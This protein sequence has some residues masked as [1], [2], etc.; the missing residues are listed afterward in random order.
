M[1]E[2]SSCIEEYSRELARS[3][4]ELVRMQL[5]LEQQI[6]EVCALFSGSDRGQVAEFLDCMAQARD[7]YSE[8]GDAIWYAKDRLDDYL[9]VLAGY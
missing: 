7:N 2:L 4:A 1:D 3:N 9:S 5:E 6:A 8:A